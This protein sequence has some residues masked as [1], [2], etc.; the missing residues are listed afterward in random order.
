MKF[1]IDIMSWP[2]LQVLVL[3]GPKCLLYQ[4]Q[5]TYDRALNRLASARRASP[6]G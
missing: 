5:S 1:T 6:H 4:N 2:S 3:P